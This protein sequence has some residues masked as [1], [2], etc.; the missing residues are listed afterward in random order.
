M[1]TIIVIFFFFFYNCTF[2]FVY[3]PKI[4]E[5][6]TQQKQIYVKQFI[7]LYCQRKSEIIL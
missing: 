4:N 5:L 2:E 6:T 3:K 1:F 7:F